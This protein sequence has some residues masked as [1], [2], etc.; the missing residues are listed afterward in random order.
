MKHFMAPKTWAF[1]Y[2][3]KQVCKQIIISQ[4]VLS[5]TFQV[6]TGR[7]NMKPV[8][9]A[10]TILHA[11]EPELAIH[12]KGGC[13]LTLTLSSGLNIHIIELILPMI[14][15]TTLKIAAFSQ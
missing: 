14:Q 5:V 2:S 13:R 8:K 9:P 6:H 7:I 4:G 10:E 1:Q 12:M 3:M 15:M 11:V